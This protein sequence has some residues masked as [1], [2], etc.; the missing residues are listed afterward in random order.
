MLR[1]FVAGGPVMY[2]ILLVSVVGLA[3]AVQKAIQLL[4]QSSSTDQLMRTVKLH[5]SQN[6]PAEAMHA[7]QSARGPIAA[8]AAAAVSAY[9]KPQDQVRDAVEL[10]GR[11]Q[12]HLLEKRMTILDGIVTLAPLLGLLGTVTGLIRSFEVLSAFGGLTTPA[13][14]SGGIAEAMIT[15]AFGLI[16]AAPMML[17]SMWLSSIIDSRVAAMDACAVELIEAAAAPAAPAAPGKP[18]AGAAAGQ[19]PAD[20]RGTADVCTVS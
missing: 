4:F 6:R 1:Y 8:L 15:T 16:V 18:S 14:L 11:E 9:G 2:A 12:V 13:Q 19:A 17:I 5:L 3:L 7:A 20:A 10:A